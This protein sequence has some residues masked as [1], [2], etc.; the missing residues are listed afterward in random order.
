MSRTR[1]FEALLAPAR[2]ALAYCAV[3]QT[4]ADFYRYA[5][6]RVRQSRGRVTAPPAAIRLRSL[7]GVPVLC[8]PGQ[9]VWTLKY[10]FVS[11]FHLPPVPLPER[12][13]I[14]DLG[15][16]VGYTVAHFAH[17]YP[18]ARIVGVEMDEP[19]LELARINTAPFGARIRLMHAAVWTE[20]GTVAYDGSGEDAYQV[21]PL[22]PTTGLRHA[23]A[24]RLTS[25]LDEAGV[26]R[27][28]YLKMD[29]EGAEAAILASPLDWADRVA[30]LKIELHPP[31]ELQQCQERL[32]AHGFRCW[33]DGRHPRCLAAVRR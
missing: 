17:L 9:D 12:A 32:E 23:P 31:A 10:T 27:A 22:P 30:A 29:I 26:R 24:R 5:S 4:P 6:L 28:D 11:Q 33:S 25:L 21:V 2:A 15:C 1:R 14:V 7:G 8:R 13:T 18:A 3:L 19:N 16:N 20:D